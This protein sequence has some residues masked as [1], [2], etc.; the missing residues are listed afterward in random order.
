MRIIPAIDIIE[1]KCVRLT[2]G[3]YTTKKIYND[4]PV[5]VAKEF[6]D[7]GIK[8]LHVVDLDGAKSKQI[9]NYKMLNSICTETKLIVDFGG[10]L[11]ADNDLKIAFDSGANQVTIGSIAVSDPNLFIKWLTQYGSDKIILGSDCKN[12]KIA[13]NGWM[14]ESEINVI[15]FINKF[16]QKGIR[17]VICTD[18]AK[19][20]MLL[21]SAHDLYKE[22]LAQTKASLI[23]SGGVN[24]IQD[25]RELKSIGCE[26]A[27]I[28]KA[29]YENK[30][31]LNK[32]KTIT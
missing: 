25:L 4:N 19:D 32:L 17:S 5:E 31:T 14:K 21:G 28:G 22:I 29:I 2:I 16:V 1:G 15:D 3:D 10:G 7:N 23:A 20:G 30:I 27:I 11:K 13:T 26:A 24:S 6:E 8:Y 9:I 12:K 18:I